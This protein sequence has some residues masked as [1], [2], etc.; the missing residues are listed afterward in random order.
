MIAIKFEHEPVTSMVNKD[1][2]AT[3]VLWIDHYLIYI[4]GAFCLSFSKVFLEK[5]MKWK[6]CRVNFIFSWDLF[7]YKNNH[8]T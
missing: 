8:K 1:D 5:A 4:A 2:P 7:F 3:F 6:D